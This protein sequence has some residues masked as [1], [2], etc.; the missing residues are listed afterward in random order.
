MAKKAP[1]QNDDEETDL[2]DVPY[3]DTEEEFLKNAEKAWR[4]KHGEHK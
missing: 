3:A 1:P 2:I 4:E